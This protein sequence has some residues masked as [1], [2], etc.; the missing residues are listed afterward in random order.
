MKAAPERLCHHGGCRHF[1]PNELEEFQSGTRKLFLLA[2][3]DSGGPHQ[4]RR[5]Q[6]NRQQAALLDFRRK[7]SFRQN[8]DPRSLRHRFFDRLN[9]VELRRDRNFDFV[10]AEEP[11]E[12]PMDRDFLIEC[13]EILPIEFVRL[14]QR[15]AGEGMRRICRDHHLF[16]APGNDRQIAI[17]LGIADESDVGV[18]AQHGVIH[19]IGAKKLHEELNPGADSRELL[20]QP[21]HLGETD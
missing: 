9:V 12:L 20:T 2:V 18:I 7:R 13:H 10:F 14:E 1:A 15:P 11:L 21:G 3:D 5:V 8:T 4:F 16:F 17:G 6:G 19:L